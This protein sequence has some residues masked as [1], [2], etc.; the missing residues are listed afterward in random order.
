MATSNYKK[1]PESSAQLQALF[2][3]YK[4]HLFEY[5]VASELARAHGLEGPFLESFGGEAKARLNEYE[6][7]IQNYQRPALGRLLKLARLMAKA[8]LALPELNSSPLESIQVMGKTAQSN[9]YRDFAE[10]DIFIL[11]K[12]G[13]EIPLSLKLCG[14]GAYLNAKSAGVRSFFTRYFAGFAH[15]EQLQADFDQ[16]V[17]QSFTSMAY[18]L[19]ELAG[20]ESSVPGRWF[21][22]EWS[23]AGLSDRPGLLPPELRARVHRAYHEMLIALYQGLRRI[24]EAGLLS[25]GLAPLLGFGHPDL[26]QVSC[27][28]SRSEGE[29]GRV[30]VSRAHELRECELEPVMG[31]LKEGLSS[32]IITWGKFQLQLR[33]K[34]MN[35]FTTPGYKVNCAY[36]KIESDHD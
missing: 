31:P 13:Q 19:Y 32:F 28:E 5:L 33:L 25:S 1:F 36:K 6:Q 23:D 29:L 17:T 27:F 21:G 35:A 11:D 12:F 26:I 15:H 20:L 8:C 3:E 24:D 14:E 9:R 22:P 4:G 2:N 7:W 10:C 34:P 18:D 30:V 16:V